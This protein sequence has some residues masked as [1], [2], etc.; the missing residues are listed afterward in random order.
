[1]FLHFGTTKILDWIIFYLWGVGEAV[2]CIVGYLAASLVSA[3]WMLVAWSQL[4][5]SKMSPDITKHPL[6]EEVGVHPWL[7]ITG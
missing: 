7:K 1:M 4:E 5:Q 2:L 3:H 6:V